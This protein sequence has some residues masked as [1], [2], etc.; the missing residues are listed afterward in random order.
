MAQRSTLPDVVT[1]FRSLNER[2]E[3]IAV[4]D[5]YPKDFADKRYSVFHKKGGKDNHFQ[6]VQRLGN[7]LLVTGSFPYKTQRADLLVSRLSSRAPDPGPWGSNLVRDRDPATIDRLTSYFRIDGDYWHPGGLSL[8]GSVAVVPIENGAAGDSKIVFLDLADPAA[9]VRLPAQEID[10][11]AFKAGACAITPLKDG[12]L[13]LAVWSDSD[14]APAGIT[15]AFHLDLYLGGA[16]MTDWSF[17]AQY[18]PPVDHRFHR[19]FQG[20]DFLWEEA[21]NG[22][23]SL[24]LVGFENTEETQP[25]PLSAGE[26]RAYLFKVAHEMLPLAPVPQPA[27]LAGSFMAF[28]DSKRFETSGNWCNMD[29][30][31][32]AYVDSSQQLVVYSVYHFLAPIRGDLMTAPMV[33]KCL[34]FRATRF[35]ARIDR[36]EDAWIDLYEEPGL[37]GRRLALLGPWDSSIEDTARVTADDRVFDVT[38]SV[39]YQI[40]DDRAFVLHPQPGFTG[41]PP[42]VLTGTGAVKEVDVIGAGFGGAFRSCRFQLESV[43]VALPGAIVV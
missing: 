3:R 11:P 29:A 41:V 4:M 33:L 27:Q 9:P 28:V 6:G 17:I 10:R 12:R 37:A 35:A 18:F 24:Y 1:Q 42:L 2:G 39:R 15:A 23:E 32:C 31:S 19:K 16:G 7:H 36:I 40:P 34:E 13:I 43:A 38:A 5:G 25:N 30:G 26:N 8:L 14:V 22:S 20:L 21:P